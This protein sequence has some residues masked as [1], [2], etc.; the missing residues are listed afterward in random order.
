[1]PGAVD[2]LVES[3]CPATHPVRG[4]ADPRCGRAD[5]GLG[6]AGGLADE[7]WRVLGDELLGRGETLGV[8]LDEVVIDVVGLDQQVQQTVQQGEVG[9]GFD[10]QVEVGLGRGGGASWIDDDQLRACLDPFHHAQEQ[11]RM[12][13]GH[14]GADHEEQ[15]GVFEVL[16]GAGW[17]V[18]AEGLLVAGACAGH[19]QSRVG[20]DV[21]AAQIALGELVRQVLCLGRH[22][23]RHVHR[24]RIRAVL[25]GYRPHPACGEGDRLVDSDRLPVGVPAGPDRRLLHPS[26]RGQHV[27]RGRSLGAQPPEVRR[28]VLT[29]GGLGDQRKS[30]AV[31]R[32]HVQHHPAPHPAVSTERV[33]GGGRGHDSMVGADCFRCHECALPVDHMVLT[34]A[35]RDC[36]SRRPAEV[37]RATIRSATRGSA[38]IGAA[39]PSAPYSLRR[40]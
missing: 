35:G 1:M 29:S 10:L 21:D 28:M 31:G 27:R 2:R 32:R 26:R 16:I 36:E 19:A 34:R 12:T 39:T 18:G 6:D 33:D 20:F 37:S 23:A 9:A 13:V 40:E 8:A 38:P 4:F 3:H 7:C 15:V 17:A 22:L 11:D 25:V 30:C 24:N 5:V 14:V